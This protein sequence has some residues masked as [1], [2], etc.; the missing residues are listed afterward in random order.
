[1][2]TTSAPKRRSTPIRRAAIIPAPTTTHFLPAS[3]TNSG[4]R[5]KFSSCAFSD[6]ASPSLSARYACISSSVRPVSARGRAMTSTVAPTSRAADSFSANPP[7]APVSLVTRISAPVCRRS[8][9]FISCENGPCMAIRCAP[10]KPSASHFCSTDA[11]AS[12]RGY[13]RSRQFSTAVYASSSLLPVVSS[14]LPGC[15]FSHATAAAVSGTV[16]QPSL[17]VAGRSRRS[18]CAPVRAQAARRL[19]V[20]AAA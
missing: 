12:T 17:S 10:A 16:S 15:A 3:D 14:A 4:K 19:S 8:A 6:S 1:M 11:V 20:T 5:G 13:S 7:D 9:A 2:T 18:Y